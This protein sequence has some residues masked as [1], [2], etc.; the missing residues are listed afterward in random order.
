MTEAEVV[1]VV[2][3]MEAGPSPAIAPPIFIGGA[4]RS[5]TTLLRVILDSH[6]R[7]TCGPELKVMPVVAQ[8]WADFQTTYAPIVRNYH[9]DARAIDRLFRDFVEGLL[10]PLQARTGKARMAEKSPN[11]VFYFQH[12]F[13]MFPDSA[14]IHVL[15]DGRDVIA[16][17]LT[18]DWRTPEGNPVPYTRSAREAARYWRRAVEAARQFAR[19]TAGSSRFHEVRYE[20][21]VARPEPCL[22]EL[23]AF[24]GETWEPDVLRFHE[25]KH[26]LHAE[27]SAA[28]VQRML[29]NS[30]VGR[31]V[32]DLSGPDKTAVR[33]EI[34]DLLIELGY[35][36]DSGW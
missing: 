28:Q 23:F 17:L 35:A 4:G 34:G 32:T 19:S 15:R 12:L 13:R 33:A 16:S 3:T 27:S 18:M 6:S 7:I 21:I 1:A 14:F 26:P 8:L 25:R 29:Y 36:H 24:L 2:P 5:G 30:S 22:Q 31:W 20:N 11:N 9:L 10:K